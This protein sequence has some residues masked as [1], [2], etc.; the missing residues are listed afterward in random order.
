MPES[1]LAPIETLQEFSF[2]EE[3][4]AI[5]GRACELVAEAGGGRLTT[6]FLL[7]AAVARAE[8]DPGHPLRFLSDRLLQ[9]EPWAFRGVMGAYAAW[10]RGSN[11]PADGQPPRLPVADALA[12]YVPG[13]LSLATRAAGGGATTPRHLLA[14]LLAYQP[15]GGDGVQPGAQ[16][17]LS[18]CP[19]GAAV[20]LADLRAAL[21]AELPPA[22]QRLFDPAEPTV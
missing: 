10:Y 9:P 18:Q 5:V 11:R 6:S 22:W 17:L 13:V 12:P 2:D 19:P 4:Q 14:A 20:I 21:G 1:A 16:Y 15:T 7:M 8:A 3:T